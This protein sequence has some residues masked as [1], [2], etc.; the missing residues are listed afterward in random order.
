MFNFATSQGEICD[1]GS[2]FDL[3]GKSKSPISQPKDEDKQRSSVVYTLEVRLSRSE[4]LYTSQREEVVILF[5]S[6]MVFGD[7]RFSMNKTSLHAF[8]VPVYL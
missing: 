1:Q 4:V 3:S 2:V 6:V 5:I 8:L 7:T